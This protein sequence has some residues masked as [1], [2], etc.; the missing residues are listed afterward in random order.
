MRFQW[1]RPGAFLILIFSFT[2][3]S[4]AQNIQELEEQ[5]AILK[6][7]ETTATEEQQSF[8]IEQA[9]FEKMR[10]QLIQKEREILNSTPTTDLED[11]LQKDT[12]SLLP[13]EQAEQIAIKENLSQSHTVLNEHDNS[14]PKLKK[15]LAENNEEIAALRAELQDLRNK[16]LIAESEIE[17]LSETGNSSKNKFANTESTTDN[18]ELTDTAIFSTAKD[19][20]NKES[21]DDSATVVTVV[22]DS[23]ALRTAPNATSSI[24]MEVDSGA[25]LT[26]DD[27]RGD[28]FRISTS[29]GMRAWISATEVAFGPT[30]SAS[31][32]ATVKIRPSALDQQAEEERAFQ[33]LKTR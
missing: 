15:R 20:T 19:R 14:D 32:S 17:R 4:A 7:Q 13:T 31:P 21:L 18:N 22:A 1:A 26:V 28:W 10:M 5:V 11:N 12:K 29:S 8:E 6:A 23:G 9:E 33:L 3:N 25:R 27:R 30:N 2:S 24:I 16:L